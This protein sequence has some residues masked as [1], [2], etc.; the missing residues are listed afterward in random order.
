MGLRTLDQ[1]GAPLELMI[2]EF[3]EQA[4]LYVPLTRLDLIQ[5]YRSSEAGPAPELN[6]MGG[7]AWAKTKAR[8]K[9]AMQ[10]MTGE[11]LKLYAQRQAALGYAF[12][13]DSQMMRE[14]EDAFDYNETDDQLSAIAD[15]KRDMES[16]QPMDRLLCGD[17]GYGKTEVAMRAALKAVQDSKQV[18]VLTPTT[19]L[20]FQHFQSFKKRLRTSPSTVEMISSFRTAK[21]QKKILED[22]AAGKVDILIGTHRLL[23]KDLVFQDLGLLVVD[24]EQRFGVRHKERL[25]QMRAH[26]D[27]LAMSATP[28]PRTLHMSLL[29]LRDMSP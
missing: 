12:T 16:T 27:V 20:S 10:D 7:A 19:V 18:A 3:A 1:D 17:V 5:K 24:E 11:L 2:L 25:K 15:I 13:P 29:G 4:K 6:K 26:I 14:F 22:T 28:I 9:K 23:S 8:V 21:E